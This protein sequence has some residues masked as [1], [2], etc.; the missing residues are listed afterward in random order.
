MVARSNPFFSTT[1]TFFAP[2]VGDKVDSA[3]AQ[4]KAYGH[5]AQAKADQLLNKG[6]NLMHKA[7]V[8]VADAKGAASTAV[9]A[10]P[11]GVD[12]YAR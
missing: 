9:G 4:G 5:E 3:I 6:D 1:Q 10:S 8:K 2:S 11:T 7:G 12:L